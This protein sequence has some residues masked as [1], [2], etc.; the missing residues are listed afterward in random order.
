MIGNG[1]AKKQCL[2]LAAGLSSRMGEWKMLLPWGNI[3][4][5]DSA[6]EN[7][8]SFCDRVVLVTGYQGARLRQ[9]YAGRAGITLCHNDNYLQGMFSSIRCGAKRLTPGDFFVVPGDMP[10]LSGDIYAA[11]WQHRYH[12]RCLVPEYDG[13]CGHPVLLPADMREIILQAKDDTN[14]KTL[15]KARGRQSVPVA[16]PSIHWDLDTPV[17]YQQLLRVSLTSD[18]TF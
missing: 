4:V 1:G 8:L 3:T 11:L 13:G 5:L 18:H 12:N 2:V 17:Q 16:T 14:L 15:V 9:R 7:A 6:L 10:L